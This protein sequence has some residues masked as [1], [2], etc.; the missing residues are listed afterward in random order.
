MRRAQGQRKG[1]KKG[2]GKERILAVMHMPSRTSERVIVEEVSISGFELLGPSA[3]K[4][5]RLSVVDEARTASASAIWP[6]DTC[7]AGASWDS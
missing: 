5:A 1:G 3:P 2:T 7:G 6:V 4:A